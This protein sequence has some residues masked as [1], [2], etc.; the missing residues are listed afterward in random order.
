MQKII[1]PPEKSSYLC[2]TDFPVIEQKPI[3]K[4]TN[5]FISLCF[6]V[7]LIVVAKWGLKILS[8]IG[9][10]FVGCIFKAL[11]ALLIMGAILSYLY[12]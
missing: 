6:I 4:V 5:I 10:G 8:N 7:G 11:L 3:T 12:A 2:N 1:L 9:C